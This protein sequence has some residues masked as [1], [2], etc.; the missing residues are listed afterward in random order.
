MECFIHAHLLRQKVQVVVV[1][2]GGTGS[3][4]INGLVQL[5]TALL[6][7]GHPEGFDVTV[8]DDDTVSQSNVGRQA[9]VW[10]DIGQHKA[11]VLVNRLNQS[12][13]LNWKAQIERLAPESGSQPL[14][15][16]HLVIGCVDNRL[17]RKAIRE[18]FTSGYWLDVGNNQNDGQVVLGEMGRTP[19]VQTPAGVRYRLPTVAD[20]LP[21]TID[22]T[23]DATDDQPSCSLADALEKQSLFINRAMALHALNLLWTLFRHGRI[24]H[25][26]VFVNLESN[27]TSPL[28][29]SP[30]AW[31]R[32]GY[33][34]PEQASHSKKLVAA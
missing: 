11:T 20:L 16:S 17:A 6:A 29:I 31:G 13:G 28:A 30:E 15:P 2:A 10:S 32:F 12:F 3:H 8:I 14:R 26:G 27:R 24:E 19:F 5:H 9:F 23:L 7:L 22:E 4:V 1:G 18:C 34:V 33:H 21:E 25:S